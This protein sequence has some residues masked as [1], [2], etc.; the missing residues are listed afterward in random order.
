MKQCFSKSFYGLLSLCIVSLCACASNSSRVSTKDSTQ[1]T[2]T[3]DGD[4]IL[5]LPAGF[6]AVVFADALGEARHLA[7]NANGDVYVK[8]SRLKNGKGIYR[9]RDT[10]GDGKADKMDGFGDFEGT[11]MAI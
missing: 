6:H 10:N 4:V 3:G 8:L 11:G 1:N 5:K 7:V 9:L 2:V